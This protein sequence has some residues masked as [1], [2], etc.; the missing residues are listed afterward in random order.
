VTRRRDPSAIWP[1]MLLAAIAALP[2]AHA[3]TVY[4][5]TMPDGQVIYSDRPMPGAIKSEEVHVLRSAASSPS[6]AT[7]TATQDAGEAGQQAEDQRRVEDWRTAVADADARVETARQNLAA[8]E[9]AL[10]QGREPQPGERVGN[11]GGGSRLT[12]AYAQRV[13]QLQKN[14]AAARDALQEAQ[15]LRSQVK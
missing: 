9:E 15:R 4:K 6:S 13:A 14:V 2:S 7:A 8:A 12:D 11:V 5:H 1:T 10:E 3:Q